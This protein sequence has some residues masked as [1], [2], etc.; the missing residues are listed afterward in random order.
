M[1]LFRIRVRLRCAL[2]F[3]CVVGVS[4]S[5]SRLR[6]GCLGRGVAEVARFF[7]DLKVAELLAGRPRLAERRLCIF[8]GMYNR[9]AWKRR[10]VPYRSFFLQQLGIV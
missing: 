9:G 5:L 2:R 7:R 3:F 8:F 4:G 10:L 6:A 1:K